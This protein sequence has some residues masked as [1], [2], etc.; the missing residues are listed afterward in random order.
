MCHLTSQLSDR[1]LRVCHI[2]FDYPAMQER[3]GIRLVRQ[4]AERYQKKWVSYPPVLWRALDEAD[5]R[6]YI[7]RGAGFETGVIAAYTRAHARRFVFSSSSMIDFQAAPDIPSPSARYAYRLG[8]RHADALVVQT[9][10]QKRVAPGTDASRLSVIRSFCDLPPEPARRERDA[11]LWIGGLIDYKQPLAY[12][13]LA[14]RLPQARFRMVVHDR[15]ER[16]AGLATEVRAR[17][18]KMPNVEIVEHMSRDRLLPLYERS[19]A[20]VNTS[21]LEGFPNTFMEAWARG[22]PV[23]SL[24]VDPDATIETYGLGRAGGGS[25]DR[26]V[27]AAA[28][29]WQRRDSIEDLAATA[30]AYIAEVHDPVRIATQWAQL[31]ERL[32]SS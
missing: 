16:W 4:S 14:E 24:H 3:N 13:T 31:I 28:S 30:R 10:E 8:L 18:A 17:A 19:L 21:L 9:D 1:G 25:L 11:F 15:G 22:T 29:L 6:V 32:S 26:I 20:V 23:L 5:A 2:V 27:D 7:Q 12:L